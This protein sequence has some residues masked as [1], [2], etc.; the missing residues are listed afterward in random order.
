LIRRYLIVD[1]NRAFAENVAEILR[2][3]GAE[4]E[5][6]S[7]GVEA[8]QRLVP[9]RFAAM[10]TDMKMPG[11]DGATLVQA[12]R[13]VDPG[14]P[15]VAI[16]AY[17]QDADLEHARRQGMLSVLPK[18]V[19]ILP[20]MQTL[21][22]AR[23]NALVALVEDD[24][25]LSD[26]LSE[27]LRSRG[28]TSVTANTVLQADQIGPWRPFA[29]IVDLRLEGGPDGEAMRRLAL[30]FPALPMLVITGVE[31]APPVPCAALFSKPFNT[32]RLIQKLEAL[33]GE[34]HG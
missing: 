7:D 30:H 27:A 15:V 9:E 1:D 3:S 8:L 24:L 12:A 2:D 31:V 23:R 16:T 26:N 4:V 29:A 33:H 28:F 14:L 22:V 18:P 21:R 19:P 32:G 20:L 6:A 5:V 10:L 34:A 11:M 17:S 13:R 25:A